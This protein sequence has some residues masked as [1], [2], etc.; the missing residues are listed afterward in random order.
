[1]VPEDP[2][3]G[4]LFKSVPKELE[5]P[6]ETNIQGSVPKWLTGS[7]LRNGP[8]KFEVGEEKYKHWFDGLALMHKFSFREGKVF[9][10]NRFLRSDAYKKACKYNK[11]IL[12]E[13]GTLGVPDPCRTIFERFVTRFIPLNITDN[14]LINFFRVGDDVYTSTET[15][16][17]RKINV[18]DLSSDPKKMNLLYTLGLATASAHAQKDR[19]GITY[20]IGTTYIGGSS[21]NIIKF[22]PGKTDDP[23]KS[24]ETLCSI[25][26]RSL[27]RPSYYHSF[28]MTDN[29]FVFLEQTLY[30]N[31]SK[32]AM[33]AILKIP[34]CHC[35]EYEPEDESFFHVIEKKTGKITT[36]KY[37][38][39]ALFGMHVVNSY[40]EDGHIVFD[41]CCYDDDSILNKFYL[42]YLRNGD[43]T[44]SRSFPRPEL[45]RFVL[46]LNVNE[47]TTKGVN[48][49]T[50]PDT[51]A[52]AMIRDDG[53]VFL[54]YEV[55]SEIG[56]D[57]PRINYNGFAGRKYKYAFGCANQAAGEFMNTLVKVDLPTKKCKTWYE[58]FCYPSEPNFIERPNS[59]EEDDGIIMSTVINT[60]KQ[61]SFLLILDAKSFEEIGRAEIPEDVHYPMT[62]HGEYIG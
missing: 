33:S 22:T 51:Q 57:M 53:T 55:V 34:V 1:M 2:N 30:C 42:E 4:I 43:K 48:I 31:V 7:L 18:E 13:F 36:V 49:V 47:N 35:L 5:A 61:N 46:P 29:Y 54:N 24:A 52:T 16:N 45:R 14:N 12:S 50:L 56:I 23:S 60:A 11:I 19:D 15:F 39:V 17:P 6:I 10:Q 27:T 28:G 58:K 20:N 40:E 32:L 21:Y 38:T 9:Y 37:R 26:A 59:T 3:F 25:P 8:G 41:L 44:G 62:F